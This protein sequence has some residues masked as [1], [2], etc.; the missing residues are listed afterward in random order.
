MVNDRK[1]WL[2]MGRGWGRNG[3]KVACMKQGTLPRTAPGTRPLIGR[4]PGLGTGQSVRRSEEAVQHN[5][6][7]QRD[8]G[9]QRRVW[10]RTTNEQIKPTRVPARR[11]SLSLSETAH[12]AGSGWNVRSGPI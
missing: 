6:V 10:N 2:D 11:A 7:E 3:R 8:A 1:A 4:K 12:L 5:A 9:K